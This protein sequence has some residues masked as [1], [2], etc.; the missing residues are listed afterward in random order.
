MIKGPEKGPFDSKP[1]TLA[2]TPE[3]NFTF[4]QQSYFHP[5]SEGTGKML[6]FL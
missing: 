3:G 2:E 4:F 6:L 1:K 5:S